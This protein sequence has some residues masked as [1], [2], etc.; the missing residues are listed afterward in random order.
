MQLSGA[1][2]INGDK[3]RWVGCTKAKSDVRKRKQKMDGTK[4]SVIN[5]S[6]APQAFCCNL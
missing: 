3:A 5:E 2:Q 6:K 4:A 1:L